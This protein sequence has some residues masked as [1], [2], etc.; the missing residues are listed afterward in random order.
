M[1]KNRHRVGVSTDSD[2]IEYV[3]HMTGD[4][5]LYLIAGMRTKVFDGEE[6]EWNDLCDLASEVSCEAAEKVLD[7]TS[8]GVSQLVAMAMV[9]ANMMT[10]LFGHVEWM[11]GLM[12]IDRLVDD[13]DGDL[14]KPTTNDILN[15]DTHTM[16]G[17]DR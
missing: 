14:S 6:Q 17:N 13:F 16:P 1:G 5:V 12:E 2:F 4:D 9:T 11:T 8:N 7:S 15:D 3:R 10:T